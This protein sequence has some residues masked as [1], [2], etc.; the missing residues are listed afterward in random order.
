M[1]FAIRLLALAAAFSALVCAPAS[2]LAQDQW[3]LVQAVGDVSVTA[4]GATPVAAKASAK[5]PDG[6]TIR[7][8]ESGRAVLL[9]GRETI[10]MSPQ[11]VIT[12]P[13]GAKK[14]FTKVQQQSGT[15]LFKIGKK[16]EAHF[17]VD[18]PYLA[19]V[20]KGT[21]F[22]VKIGA[23]GASVHVL[24]GAVE[25]ATADRKNSFLTRAG[26][27][28]SVFAKASNDIF[29]TGAA[30]LN[31]DGAST[32]LWGTDVSDF[33]FGGE[34]AAWSTQTET[35]VFH[36]TGIRSLRPK[37][38]RDA[39]LTERAPERLAEAAKSVDATLGAAA[40]R[41][42]T[43]KPKIETRDAEQKPPPEK[44][45]AHPK[46]DAENRRDQSEK[47]DDRQKENQRAQKVEK[48]GKSKPE[49]QTGSIAPRPVVKA[50]NVWTVT[51]AKGDIK[52][53]GYPFANFGDGQVRTLPP[54]TKVETGPDS[55]LGVAHG[56]AEYVIDAN[57]TAILADASS[58]D[59]PKVVAGSAV[60]YKE[61]S[62]RYEAV[63]NL[64]PDEI[65]SLRESGALDN[66]PSE[67][68][69]RGKIG[70]ASAGTSGPSASVGP[71]A[72]APK[73]ISLPSA[74]KKTEEVRTQVIGGLT[75]GLYGLTALLVLAFGAQWVWRRYRAKA[76]APPAETVVQSRLRSIKGS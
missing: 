67:E 43:A 34:T 24:E 44:N 75:L 41:K 39:A 20:V 58:L 68:D 56:T 25:V 18:T 69:A 55:R 11:S 62:G 21:T 61:D 60:R 48:F 17:E 12:L 38:K 19:A 76:K 71:T 10:V 26:Q 28:S 57:S 23:A 40:A 54:G 16:P 4:P 53:D 32:E 65:A 35:R 36:D 47:A 13:S 70:L 33:E 45:A 9:R 1:S 73:L 59:V 29:T 7:T 2:A 8:G 66:A 27:I 15:L 51:Q 64:T 46:K 14:D 63:A 74:S 31:G 6:A 22:T 72:P 42:Q 30:L 3:T 5:L 50:A 37:P 52:I 49:R